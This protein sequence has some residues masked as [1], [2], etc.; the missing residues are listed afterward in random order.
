MPRTARAFLT[1]CAAL[2]LGAACGDA[3]TAPL[4]VGGDGTS[5]PRVVQQMTVVHDAPFSLRDPCGS[6]VIAFAGSD[7]VRVRIYSDASSRVAVRSHYEGIGR[8]TSRSYRIDFEEDFERPH[9][10]FP[11]E[12]ELRQELAGADGDVDWVVVVDLVVHDGGPV[13]L[14][15]AASPCHG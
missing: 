11:A 6:D 5:A 9:G 12:F 10:D 1:G 3:G 7:T 4:S 14:F 13:Q 2:L 8:E 15:R